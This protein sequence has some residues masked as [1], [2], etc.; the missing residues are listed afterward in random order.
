MSVNRIERGAF[1]LLLMTIAYNVVE[2]VIAIVNGVQVKSLTLVAFGADSYL[3]VAA[4][5]AVLWR[6]SYQNEEEGEKAERS[7][8]RFVGWTFLLLAVAVTFQGVVSLI[9]GSDAEGS[10]LGVALLATSLTLMPILALAKL[11]MA[12]RAKIPALAAEA[13]ETIACSYLSL[14]ALLGLGAT[15]V[16]G[17]SQLDTLTAL[18]LVPWLVREGLQGVRGEACFDGARPCFC[19]TCFYGLRGCRTDSCMPLCC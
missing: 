13:R 3:E 4:A 12:A 17:W 5:A 8:F 7:A 10:L 1:L 19:R 14:T 18:L 11:R 2:G 9:Q 16:V 6:L 15:F